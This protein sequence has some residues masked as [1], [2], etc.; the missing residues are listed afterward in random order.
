MMICACAI[1]FVNASTESLIFSADRLQN[2][3]VHNIGNLRAQMRLVESYSQ[4]V[5]GNTRI[6]TVACHFVFA[7]IN[8]FGIVEPCL[9]KGIGA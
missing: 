9:D 8:V 1:A 3:L 7:Y 4:F 6:N 2:T 5:P